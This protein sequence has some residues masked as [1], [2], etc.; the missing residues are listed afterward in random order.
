MIKSGRIWIRTTRKKGEIAFS[1]KKSVS[2]SHIADIGNLIEKTLLHLGPWFLGSRDQWFDQPSNP[3]LVPWKPPH[4]PLICATGHNVVKGSMMQYCMAMSGM[5]HMTWPSSKRYMQENSSRM[6]AIGQWQSPWQKCRISSSW[7]L[8]SLILITSRFYRLIQGMKCKKPSCNGL[9]V[10]CALKEVLIPLAI[11]CYHPNYWCISI[12]RLP[13][14]TG[15]TIS[16]VAPVGM[17]VRTLN[18]FMHWSWL[19]LMKWFYFNLWT[20]FQLPLMRF[21]NMKSLASCFTTPD[22]ASRKSV[23]SNQ[24]W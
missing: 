9:P 17:Q 2:H 18:T 12:N 7:I 10:L 16:S 3:H 14:F 15:K 6:R 24:P 5:M 4:P 22:T 8:P 20:M 19:Q 23:V 13:M 11:I 21:D 1:N